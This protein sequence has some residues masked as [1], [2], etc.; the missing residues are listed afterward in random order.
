MAIIYI[1]VSQCLFAA[2]LIF[3]KKPLNIADKILGSWLLVSS[4]LFVFNLFLVYYNIQN[5]IWQIPF[6]LTIAFPEFLVLYTKYIT[7]GENKFKRYDILYFI[8]SFI[9][10]IVIFYSYLKNPN[11][12]FS[13]DVRKY[14]LPSKYLSYLLYSTLSI[15]SLIAIRFIYLYKK[16]I[17]Q[18]YS[19]ESSKI[20]LSWLLVVIICYFVTNTFL[21]IVSSY[22]F[23][24]L[25]F[26]EV[27]DIGNGIQ[28]I[29]IY[30]L[31]Y[32]GFKQQYLVS[33]SSPVVLSK[34][35]FRESNPE[36]YQ[37]SGLKDISKVEEYL[38]SLVEYMNKFE[39]W[40]DNELS[41]AKLSE[42]TG[43]PRHY[44]TQILNDNLQKNFYTFV[45][46]Y[47]TE[48]A[49]KLIVSQNYSHWSIVS[50]AFESGF[51]SKAAFNSFF[52]KYTGMTPSDFK[53]N[54]SNEA[55]HT[56]N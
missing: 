21:L 15:Y 22:Y 47:R 8:P 35:L 38:K 46:E 51:N 44:I 42:L 45:N 14:G 19:F 31:S 7:I 24:F 39:P 56:H 40:K 53:K 41:V 23:H 36:K 37:K 2:L 34:F 43:I 49:K 5:Y 17:N 26:D 6:M 32:F 1:G 29:F 48:Y 12:F 54:Y 3:S 13:V 30:I 27:R 52:K 25:K 20:N 28:L 33:N 10:L 50:I 16:Q 11:D 18:S 55:K 4:L 9:T